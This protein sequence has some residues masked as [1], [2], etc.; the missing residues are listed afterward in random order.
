MQTAQGV[1]RLTEIIALGDGSMGNL[2]TNIIELLAVADDSKGRGLRRE[3]SSMS[4]CLKVWIWLIDM[5][6]STSRRVDELADIMWL[7]PAHPT[8]Q[9][10]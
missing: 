4:T 2:R 5:V 6:T 10:A 1:E 9:Y 7:Q 8:E 3:S